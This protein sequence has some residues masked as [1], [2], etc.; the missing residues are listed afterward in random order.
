MLSRVGKDTDSTVPTEGP[1][2]PTKR[3]HRM[4]WLIRGRRWNRTK[5]EL[6]RHHNAAKPVVERIPKEKTVRMFTDRLSPR[7][8]L[9]DG[10]RTGKGKGVMEGSTDGTK[11]TE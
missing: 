2:T 7:A 6:S 4:A 9:V 5:G 8:A 11:H 1:F 3:L 10:V